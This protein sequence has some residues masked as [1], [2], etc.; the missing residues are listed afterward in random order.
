VEYPDENA[1]NIYTD[2][3]MLSGPRRGGA[4]LL[5]I[6][7]DKDGEEEQREHVLGGYSDATQNQMELV[8]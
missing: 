5:F 3:S 4:G 8:S 1:L 7:I 6:V 2:G